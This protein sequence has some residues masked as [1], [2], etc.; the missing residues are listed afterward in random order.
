M[1]PTIAAIVGAGVGAFITGMSTMIITIINKKTEKHRYKSE[2]AVQLATEEYRASW[3]QARR[4]GGVMP[5][6][7]IY[8]I[9]A[10]RFMN[11][12]NFSKS[13]KEMAEQYIKIDTEAKELID[14]I[15]K[16]LK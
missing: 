2:L 12:I 3:E 14:I 6:P 5:P 7:H 4:K 16:K 13:L 1:D 8:F 15:A 9:C 10:L 11:K